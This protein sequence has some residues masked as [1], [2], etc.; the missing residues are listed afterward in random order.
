[1][2]QEL[3]AGS[4]LQAF[5]PAGGVCLVGEAGAGVVLPSLS[6]KMRVI[7]VFQKARSPGLSMPALSER[8]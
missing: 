2:K 1:M 7:C 5:C 4:H 3:E 6:S 8:V